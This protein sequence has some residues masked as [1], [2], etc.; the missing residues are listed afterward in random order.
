LVAEEP[1]GSW[2]IQANPDGTKTPY[3]LEFLTREY[4]YQIVLPDEH[5]VYFIGEVIYINNA[6]CIQ[7][8]AVI[9]YLAVT[10]VQILG[11]FHMEDYIT[12]AFVYTYIDPCNDNTASQKFQLSPI[13]GGTF[14][15]FHT[16]DGTEIEVVNV[17]VLNTVLVESDTYRIQPLADP[18]LNTDIRG[19]VYNDGATNA[20][21]AVNKMLYNGTQLYIFGL[22]NCYQ[23]GVGN[24]GVTVKG[25]YSIGIYN[26]SFGG[27][28]SQNGAYLPIANVVGDGYGVQGQQGS[29]Y[30]DN[31]PG[32]I[33]D[34]CFVGSKLC[35]AGQ[36]SF[37]TIDTTSSIAPPAGMG[38]FAVG[39]FALTGNK[40]VNTPS[41]GAV[42][43]PQAICLR[44]SV[45]Q[46]NNIIIANN[47]PSN[48]L[49]FFNTT[50]GAFTVVTGAV[51]VGQMRPWNNS[52][53]GAT[54]DIG[55]G[56][57]ANDVVLYQDIT[58]LQTE[59]IWF[60]TAT[61][62]VAQPLSPTPT[63]VAPDYYPKPPPGNLSSMGIQLAQITPTIQLQMAGKDGY[64]VYDPTTAGANLVFS[65]TFFKDG[66][67]YSN[68]NFATA[69]LLLGGRSQSYV[70]QK[71]LKGWIQVGFETTG[72]TYS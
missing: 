31:L 66:T 35:I 56:L 14:Q 7:V 71:G 26:T 30:P 70:A 54:I 40:W 19:L 15:F 36:W 61:G 22:Y 12:D 58:N 60:S 72:L 16:T 11:H 29:P 4:F 45:S 59:V 62:F 48:V 47:S 20:T 39:D 53:A 33:A 6:R 65:G 28:G 50:T 18:T 43:I 38:G 41:A 25:F 51:P 57:V 2:N 63:N 52:I 23:N 49:Q 3:S 34:A 9:T 42:A 1:A 8:S 44:I 13:F 69:G 37:L 68:A 46:A 5:L 32:F 10:R 24:A 27:F 21:G 64:Y 55:F 17:A 67:G